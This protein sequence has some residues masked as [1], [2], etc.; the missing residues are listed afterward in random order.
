MPYA[1]L[2][3]AASYRQ[4]LSLDHRLSRQPKNLLGLQP[5]LGIRFCAS[6]R[7]VPG[8]TGP[9]GG[10]GTPGEGEDQEEEEDEE[11]GEPGAPG[12][13]GAARAPRLPP[14]AP[15]AAGQAPAPR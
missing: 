13:T 10:T 1:P 3:F 14:A 2:G 7:A 4:P 11:E 6:A 9:S 5:K 12:G 8:S 15:P